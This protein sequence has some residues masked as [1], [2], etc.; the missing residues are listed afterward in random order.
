MSWIDGAFAWV[1]GAVAAI[2]LTLFGAATPS[3]VI[4]G[5]VEGEYVR[6]GPS[7]PGTIDQVFVRRGQRVEAAQPLFALEAVRERAA[8][9][10]AAA[11]LA[12]AKAVLDN[13]QKGR[14]ASEIAAMEAQKDQADA[15]LRLTEAQLRR[16]ESL[17]LVNVAAVDRLDSARA[18]VERD[19]ARVAEM[20]A[21]IAT[22]RLA[23]RT[24]EV[25]AAE[26]Q[27]TAADAALR[28]AEWRLG[29]RAVISPVAGVI[30]DVP[31]R[32]GEFVNI[33]A[34]I[35][36]ILPADHIKVRF[37]VPQATRGQLS[38]GQ[39][40]TIAWDGGRAEGYLAYLAD[41]A[42]FTPPILYTRE[43]RQKFVFLAEARLRRPDPTLHPGQPVEVT[44]SWPK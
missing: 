20:S 28:Q 4:Q 1:Q 15:S 29:Q 25:R 26:A 5:Y 11:R 31:F 30:T 41:T 37:F 42:E 35:V 23:A 21:Q 22:A 12:N 34:P 43:Q 13:L 33:A 18:A 10:E 44:L 38:L 19:R 24:D 3:G 8:R 9:D 39:D 27:V 32:V 36:S 2:G 40:L 6:V 16:T 14:R 17:A 7:E